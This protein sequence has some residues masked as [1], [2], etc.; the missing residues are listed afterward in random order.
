MEILTE[1][2]N[3]ADDGKRAESN[4]TEMKPKETQERI[5]N[6]NGCFRSKCKRNNSKWLSE[7]VENRIRV[8]MGRNKKRQVLG[9][10]KE[11]GTGRFKIATNDSH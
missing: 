5:K 10:E 2:A 9:K 3:M 1:V 7:L 8:A 4:A 11:V 6:K